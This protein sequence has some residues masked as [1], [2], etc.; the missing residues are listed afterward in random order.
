LPCSYEEYISSSKEV[1]TEFELLLHDEAEKTDA[2]MKRCAAAERKCELSAEQLA[3]ANKFATELQTEN[4]QLKT[5]CATVIAAK[6][7]LELKEDQ[8]AGQ[9]RI[10]ESSVEELRARCETQ[11]EELVFAQGDVEALRERAKDLEEDLRHTGLEMTMHRTEVEELRTAAAEREKSLAV[12]REELASTKAGAAVNDI[13]TSPMH[14]N[15]DCDGKA[16]SSETTAT[17]QPT[18]TDVNADKKGVVCCCIQ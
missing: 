4:Q 11:A 15:R 8:Y 13:R 2:L 1:E 9:I 12:L 3:A 14:A 18:D 10:L 5:R 16:S 7:S 17:L 6:C